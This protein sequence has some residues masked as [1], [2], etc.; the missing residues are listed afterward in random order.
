MKKYAWLSWVL[1]TAGVCGVCSP[2]VLPAANGI[3]NGTE[4]ALWTNSAN[5][6]AAPYPSGNDTASFTNAGNSQTLIDIAGLSAIKSITFDSANAAGYTIGSGGADAQAVNLVTDG[7]I[8]LSSPVVADQTFATTVQLPGNYTFVNNTLTRLLTFNTVRCTGGS[9]LSLNGTGAFSFLGNLLRNGLSFSINQNTTN[10]VTLYGTNNQVNAWN[11]NGTKAILNLA[12]GALITF[13]GGGGNNLI[14]SQDA[15]INGPG[16]MILSNGGGENFAD[17]SVASGKTLTIHARLTGATG[18]EYWHDRNFGTIAL[19]GQN[20]F[21]SNVI[22]NAAGTLAV[23]NVGNQGSLTS[24][25]GAGSK[26]IFN[27]TYGGASCVK[28]LGL[29]E[30]TDRIF[31]FRKDGILEQAG[32]NGVLKLTSNLN[33]SGTL[34]VTLR[35]ST[36]GIGEI[37]GVIS[38]STTVAKSGSGTWFLTASNTYSG[39]TLVNA[40]NLVLSGSGSARLATG[41]TLSGGSLILFNTALSNSVD[42]LADTVAVTLT[43]G[44]LSFSNDVSLAANYSETIGAVTVSSNSSTFAITPA[45]EGQTATLRLASIVRNAGATINFTGEGLGDSDRARIFITGQGDGLIGTWATVNGTQYA[46]Y[47]STRGVYAAPAGVDIAARG[48]SSVITNNAVLAVRIAYPGE[49]GPITLESSPVSSAG[50]L[51]QNS[52]TPAMVSTTSTLFKVSEIIVATNKAALTIGT[53]VRE[54]AL[55][56]LTPGGRLSLENHSLSGALTIQANIVSNTTACSLIKS[57]QGSVVLAGE[58]SYGGAT[59]IDAGELNMGVGAHT[60]GALTV[61]SATLIFTNQAASS[62]Y[63]SSNTAYIGNNANDTG[64]MVI[65]GNSAWSGYLYPKNASQAILAIGHSGRGILTLQDNACVT[66]RLYV[67]NNS[68][69]AGAIYQRGGVMHNWGG[70]SADGRIGMYGYGYYELNSGTFTNNGWTHLAFGSQSIGILKQMGGIFRMGNI[71]DGNLGISRGGTGVVYVAGG[72]FF[73]AAT[74]DVGEQWD[75]GTTNGF[76]EFTVTGGRA[77][78]S[79]DIYMADRYSMLSV[80]NLKG[81]T[82]AANRFVRAGRSPATAVVNFDGGVFQT[83]TSGAVFGTGTNAPTVVNVYA[84]GVTVNTTNLTCTVPVPLRAPAGSGVTSIG[85]TPRDGYIGPP[86]VAISGGGGT[87]ATAVATFDSTLGRVTGIEITSPGFG[88]TSTPTVTL[89]GGGTNVQTALGSVTLGANVCGGLTKLG[90]GTLILSATNTYTGVTVISN[91]TVRLG[92]AGALPTNNTVMISNGTLDLGSTEQKLAAVQVMERGS[93]VNGVLQCNQ[94]ALNA[95][96]ALDV[97]TAVN[98]A[99]TIQLD[100]GVL[101]I[102]ATQPGLL[103]GPVPNNGNTWDSITTNSLVQLTTRMANTNA[104]PPWSD[105]VTYVYVGYIWNRAATNVT[106]TF[107]ENVD[108]NALLKIDGITYLNDGGW[109]TPSKANVTVTPGPHTFEARFGNGGGGAG[110]VSGD[111]ANSLSWWKT[112]AFGFGVDYQGRNETNIANYVALVDPGDGSVLTRDLISGSMTNRLS[113]TT[114]IELGATAILDL[115]TNSYSQTLASL[116]GS[117]VVSNGFLAVTGFIDPGGTNAIGTLTLANCAGLSGT[118]RIDVVHDGETALCDRLAVVGNLDVSA[119]NL[120][121]ANPS[122]LNPNK[123]YTVLTVSGTRT[124][125]FASV[126]L[127]DPRWRVIYRNDGSVVLI[128]ANGTLIKVM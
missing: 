81:G 73:T 72:N 125:Q 106:W 87:G 13:Y 48:P 93:I 40:G 103:E 8:T 121:I 85:I 25:L 49:S 43:G 59:L 80:V 78:I 123:I 69:S 31:E 60:I 114:S 104:K 110:V 32:S 108:D 57:G 22:M 41:L 91:G 34:T 54:G 92:V 5:W 17:N 63:V 26:V 105:N 115:G 12:E 83:R 47:S 39:A 109:A 64:R 111:G 29:G 62:I 42:R 112:T 28:Y 124:G 52:D 89:S 77:E 58:N 3:W 24:N 82:V 97:G 18:F 6:S 70:S 71:Y 36:E 86:M 53:A 74:L 56:T 21:A 102:P 98:V 118:L 2:I 27:S 51:L 37:A 116:S 16:A 7:F 120:T 96:C 107:A 61:N 50:S 14:A 15:V 88:Y 20:D 94:L 101:R 66:Q 95:G 67:G 127:P 75:N 99:Q 11:I 122:Q 1:R 79:G 76:A 126:S 38:G 117:G 35:G 100:S 128:Y 23:T 10:V 113:A 68:G 30:I 55:S 90:S 46:A 119:L 84:N 33:S 45:A 4:S 65:G 44:T 19:F 9:T